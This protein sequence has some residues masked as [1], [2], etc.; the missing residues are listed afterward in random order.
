M[1][2][3]S[4]EGGA[5][6]SRRLGFSVA[7]LV[8][9][10]AVPAA[11]AAGPAPFAAQGGAGVLTRD[12]SIRYLAL[13]AGTRT[14]VEAMNT[15]SGDVVHQRTVPG[16]LGIPLLTYNGFGEGLSRDGRTLVLQTMNV[17]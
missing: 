14:R 11:L 10:A 8:V 12:G 5:E 3:V 2:G 1:A 7:A 9:L 4:V 15:R 16:V 17:N 6:M 13:N